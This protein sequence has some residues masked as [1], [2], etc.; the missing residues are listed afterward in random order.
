[1]SEFFQGATMLASFAVAVFFVRYWLD[2]HDRLFG[3]FAVAFALF[4]VNRIV[5]VALD[6]DSEAR[7]WVYLIRAVAF[8]AII[9]AI[10]DKNLHSA[11]GDET[12]LLDSEQQH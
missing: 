5:L 12:P 10:I 4:G 8:A 6:H 3:V 1:M 2:T 9:A 7:T 11:A